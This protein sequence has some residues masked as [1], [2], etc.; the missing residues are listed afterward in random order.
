MDYGPFHI[1]SRTSIHVCMSKTI[2]MMHS[3]ELHDQGMRR[4]GKLARRCRNIVR[5]IEHVEKESVYMAYLLKV[6]ATTMVLVNDP[7]FGCL[8]L[9]NRMHG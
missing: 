8:P 9:F 3:L 6:H 7:R 4:E 5:C 2:A 1:K